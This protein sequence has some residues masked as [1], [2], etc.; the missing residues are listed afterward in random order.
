MTT[1]HLREPGGTPTREPAAPTR[2]PG[3][4]P[5][6]EPA[7]PTRERTAWVAGVRTAAPYVAVF[8]PYGL[9]IGALADEASVDDLLGWST[10]WLNYAGASQL[11]MIR[12]LDEGAAPL[13]I[14][15][16]IAMIS[17]RL[18]A[19]STTMSPH[20]RGAPRWWTAVASYVLVDP[21][22]LI[23]TQRRARPE[24]RDE[25]WHRRY[26]LGAAVTLW[27]TWLINCGIGVTLG[28]HLAGHV[29]AGV[30]ADLM[31]VSMAA[32]LARDLGSRV[33]VTVALVLGVPAVLLPAGT[34]ATV[35]ALVAMA[36]A[37]I[38]ERRLGRGGAR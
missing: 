35:V 8:A 16:I 23:A 31:L 20:W 38:A 29:P 36:T 37:A 1:T 27:V 21:A 32:A 26:Y 2:E 15:A 24:R 34:G 30:L 13:A 10:A 28:A 7:A 14:V 6:R 19:Y 18:V 17:L 3:G 33:A 12:M 22:Y 5:A 25:R 11:V 4:T 9:V